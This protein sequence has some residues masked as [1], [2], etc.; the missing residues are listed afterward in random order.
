LASTD[1]ADTYL[2]GSALQAGAQALA[3]EE[4]R[5]GEFC[6]LALVNLARRGRNR[7]R[8]RYSASSSWA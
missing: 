5:P 2:E 1:G 3:R 6:V 4:A 8:S 7:S